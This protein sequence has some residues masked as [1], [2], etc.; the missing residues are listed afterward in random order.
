MKR[1]N[2][3]FVIIMVVLGFTFL[4]LAGCANKE[5]VNESSGQPQT[6]MKQEA[7]KP[8]VPATEEK[9]AKPASETGQK[10]AAMAELKDI[11]FD[12]DK[13]NLRPDRQRNFNTHAGSAAEKC[14]I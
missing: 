3:F 12:F 14:R 13:Y 2:L 4:L 6:E 7:A 1:I 8:N 9:A 11:H 10:I 5:L